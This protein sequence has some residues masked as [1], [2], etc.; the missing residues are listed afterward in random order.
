MVVNS[1]RFCES[2]ILDVDDV[3]K[4]GIASP[5]DLIKVLLAGADVGMVTSEIYRSGP[6]AVAHMLE[7]LNGYLGRHHLATVNELL[8]KRPRFGTRV[9][10]HDA[11]CLAQEG[12][13]I[14]PT[15]RAANRFGDR[16]G[17]PH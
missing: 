13:F 12:D 10:K 7:G 3:M 14:D 11:S 17:H 16:W 6:D 9:R 5:E 15:P 4:K 8:E 2:S 1:G